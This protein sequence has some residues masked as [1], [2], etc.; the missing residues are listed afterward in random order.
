MTGK[1][2]IENE[3]FKTCPICGL[4]EISVDYNGIFITV[5]CKHDCISISGTYSDKPIISAK[6]KWNQRVNTNDYNLTRKHCPFCGEKVIRTQSHLIND[7]LIYYAFC[8]NCRASTRNREVNLS[9]L[10]ETALKDWNK[11]YDR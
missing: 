3:K 7:K 1:E 11:K 4:D 8:I 5:R 2:M 10:I 9:T 6:K